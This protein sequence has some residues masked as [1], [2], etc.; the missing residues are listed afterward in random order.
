MRN[1]FR[2][3]VF[4]GGGYRFSKSSSIACVYVPVIGGIYIPGHQ[5]AKEFDT[6]HEV[7]TYVADFLDFYDEYIIKQKLPKFIVEI[8]L[9]V[10]SNTKTFYGKDAI[11]AI[12]KI[13]ANYS[14]ELRDFKLLY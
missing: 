7:G 13:E 9:N 11:T 6:I 10:K 5:V 12:D 14:K 8:H 2:L 4:I 1:N 3:E